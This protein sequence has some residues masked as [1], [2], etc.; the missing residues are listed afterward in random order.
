MTTSGGTGVAGADFAFVEAPAITSLTPSSGPTTG[1]TTVTIGGSGFSGAS[2]VKFG[3]TTATTF[4]VTSATTIKAKT[5]A[6]P[7]GGVAVSVTTSGGSTVSS[8]DYTF[9]APEPVVTTF[10]PTNGPTTG[11][12]TVTITG[13]GFIGASSV[14]FGTTTASGFTVTDATTI[15]AKTRAHSAASLPV[16]V[17]TTGGTSTAPSDFA[18]VAVPSISTF[19]PTSGP[20]TG[21]TVVTITGTNLT[22]A[23]AVM[24]GTTTAT[25]FTVTSATTIKA[26]TRSQSVGSVKISVTTGEGTATSPADYT[27]AADPSI[28]TFTPARGPTTGGTT[29]TV[30]GTGFLG[31]TSVKFGT[32]TTSGFTVTS[33]TTIRATTN[34]HAAATLTISVS[35]AGGTAVSTGDF[36]FAA[37][38]TSSGGPP[39]TPLVVCGSS[40][41]LSGPVTAPA[42]AVTVEP[43]GTLPTA[44][45]SHGADTTFWLA[46]GTYTLG[47]T[48]F[49]QV[50]PAT[51]DTF[52]GAPGAII[53]GQF[54][55]LYAFT[56]TAPGSP[57]STS[58]SRIS[59]AAGDNG[60]RGGEPRHRPRDG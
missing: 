35:T 13:T 21:D 3:S 41:L 28:S 54:V 6:H 58:P 14:K 55:N 45:L 11:G 16:S 12:T 15:K 25:T 51:G 27:F 42:G 1:G 29:V 23:T 18:F 26:T 44:V 39:S 53:D 37:V 43:G 19:T 60:T 38:A 47:T 32:T 56:Q 22:G 4:T 20:A 31:T 48:A 49:S 24:F 9:V 10:T 40:S 59:A 17:T 8:T 33:A 2:S 52:I 57:S 30:T 36:T 5:K 46:P 7:A 34:P 50:I